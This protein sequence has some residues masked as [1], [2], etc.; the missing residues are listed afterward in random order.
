MSYASQD[1]L[2]TRFG[3]RELVELTDRADPPSG[4]VDAAVVAAALADTDGE[5]N[6]YLGVRYPL[7][8]A[9]IPTLI[10]NLACDIARYRL[11]EHRATVQ[12]EARY[13]AAIALL[14]KIRDGEQQLQLASGAEVAASETVLLDGEDRLFTR[15]RLKGF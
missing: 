4:E 7:P 6:G 2:V 10:V 8:L 3:E 9:E 5:I 14:E 13:E 11:F 1:D 15:E 12:V